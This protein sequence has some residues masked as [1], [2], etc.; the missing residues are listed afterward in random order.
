MVTLE[1]IQQARERIT[2]FINRTPLLHSQELSNQ[3]HADVF[4][5]T[6]NLQRTGS[7]KMR[8]AIN[9][10]LDVVQDESIKGVVAASSG[11]FAQSMTAAAKYFKRDSVVVMPKQASP[12]KIAGVRELGGEI[13]FGPEDPAPRN[14]VVD[15]LVEKR[16]LHKLSPFDDDRMIAGN[17]TAG[18]EI[19]EDLV[20]P[21]VVLVPVSGGGLL[22]GV[23]AAVRETRP[24][25]RVIGVQ[26]AGNGSA[27][28]AMQQGRPTTKTNIDTIADG[29]ICRRVG[30][31]TFPVIKKYV[32]DI[33]L[34]P[35]DII[36]RAMVN[37]LARSHL[38]VEAAGAVGLAAMMANTV[39]LRRRKVVIVL[40]GGN[41]D[42]HTM[43]KYMAQVLDV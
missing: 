9:T 7:F 19:M 35:E 13:V 20:D 4:L 15:E 28:L 3:L 39:S 12:S 29:L 40:S 42:V 30:D 24:E 10:M 23:A 16:G 1:D 11:N 21:D 6:E 41:V 5:K 2:P 36:P 37:L 38:L 34:A 17:G 22:A 8:G 27:L 31:I 26:G 18:L 14:R 32:E 33:A 43:R 25:T